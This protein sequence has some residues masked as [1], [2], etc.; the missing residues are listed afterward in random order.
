MRVASRVAVGSGVV[1]ALLAGAA[2]YNV[3]LVRRVTAV[4]RRLAEAFRSST[5]SLE[6]LQILDHYEEYA[7]K[8]YVTRDDAYA[9]KLGEERD[10]F[11]S[12]V[13]ELSGLDLSRQGSAAVAHLG[14]SWRRFPLA[15]L[16]SQE[17]A[18]KLRSLDQGELLEQVAAPLEGLHSDAWALADSARDEI[19]SQ[20]RL[21]EDTGHRAQVVAFGVVGMAVLC[22]AV[23][24]VLTVRSINRPLR[25][26]TAGTQAVARG[27]FSCR[28]AIGGHDEFTALG[29]DFN[30]MVQALGELDGLKRDFLSH[31]SHELRTPLV[32]MQETDR[33][34]LE[35]TPGPLTDG[36]KRLLAL[37][38]E[39][40]GRLAGMID[41]LL[42]LA[43]AE[44]GGMRFDLRPHDLRDIAEHAAAE[45]AA[46]LRAAA[47]DLDLELSNQ[48]VVAACDRDRMIQV[49]ENLLEN[50]IRFSPRRGKISLR[51]A[52]AD[53]LGG[54]AVASGRPAAANGHWVGMELADQGP[55][56]PDH[57]KE[58]IFDRFFRVEQER[59]RTSGGVGLGLAICREIVAAHGGAI[60]VADGVEGGSVF[61]FILP[62]SAARAEGGSGN[63]A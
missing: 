49:I 22:S 37:N 18:E 32:A 56:V 1:L 57:E 25:R 13:R 14:S 28:L 43:R 63:A 6:L 24:L 8:F 9:A 19:A 50:A 41:N 36:Q 17:I 39:A 42:D 4:N 12:R 46:R 40:G 21:V 3:S 27:D 34:L 15:F 55:G 44:A 31:V 45:F 47:I 20:A 54:A 23:V 26:L 11:A 52:A 38:L 61:S 48:P 58:R 2:A 62:R 10:A 51:V 60:W 29:R 33:L 59:Q 5:V 16:S 30:T 53:H 35:G 7:R